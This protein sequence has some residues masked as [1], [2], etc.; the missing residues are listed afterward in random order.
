MAATQPDAWSFYE[1]LGERDR[2]SLS[3]VERNVAAICDLRQEVNSGGFDSYFR[4]WGGN[5]APIALS[6]LPRVLGQDWADLL[7]AA[8]FLIGAEYPTDVDAREQ[9]LDSDEL[10]EELDALNTRYFELESATDADAL[11]SSYLSNGVA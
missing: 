8:M 6:A 7:A 1:E 5:T 10:D 2:D 4:Y 9:R 11:L 3:E